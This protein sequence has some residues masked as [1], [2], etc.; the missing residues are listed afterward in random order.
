MTGGVRLLVFAVFLFGCA[1][2]QLH[3]ILHHDPA[4]L[5]HGTK[6]FLDGGKL[7]RD[8]FE[9]NPPLIFYLT[10]APVWVARQ[11]HLF[12]VDV[13]VLYVFALIALSLWVSWLL[14]RDDT[15]LPSRTRDCM[16]IAVAV[17]LNR[18]LPAIP[19]INRL[20]L[21]PPGYAATGTEGPLLKPALLS[22]TSVAGAISVGAFH[23][24]TTMASAS[25]G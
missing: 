11:L 1:S 17:A 12:E 7:Y 24:G 15:A 16:L 23:C 9:L 18:F 4:W 13:F 10:V 5:I 2:S 14:S 8:V 21:T 20:I 19:F 3:S 6:I 22:G 25:I